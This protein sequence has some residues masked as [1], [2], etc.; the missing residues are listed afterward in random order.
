VRSSAFER[1]RPLRPRCRRRSATH[2]LFFWVAIGIGTKLPRPFG[3]L[4]SR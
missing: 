4:Q 1:I 3:R 2:G